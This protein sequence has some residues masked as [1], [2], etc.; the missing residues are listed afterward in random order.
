MDIVGNPI[1]FH[2]G[3]PVQAMKDALADKMSAAFNDRDLALTVMGRLA[4]LMESAESEGRPVVIAR[5]HWIDDSHVFE[6]AI[7]SGGEPDVF[8]FLIPSVIDGNVSSAM[9]EAIQL[10]VIFSGGITDVAV[11][12]I[13][14]HATNNPWSVLEKSNV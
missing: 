12:Q 5:T 8:S 4:T 10:F 2:Q 1:F 6:I 7:F 3:Q 9:L 11:C 13:L 14:C